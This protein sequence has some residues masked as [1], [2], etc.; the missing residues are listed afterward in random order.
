MTA[1]KLLEGSVKCGGSSIGA[2]QVTLN[3]K[4]R[5]KL[6]FLEK[7]NFLTENPYARYNDV[8]AGG[9]KT[10][11]TYQGPSEMSFN[12]TANNAAIPYTSIYKSPC[13]VTQRTNCNTCTAI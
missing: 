13:S 5:N 10:E 2:R 7:R 9:T 6:V 4:D 3:S 12:L 1:R 11:R 8:A